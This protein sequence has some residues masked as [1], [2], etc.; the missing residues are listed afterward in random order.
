MKSVTSHITKNRH[1]ESNLAV[2]CAE[3]DTAFSGEN[4]GDSQMN[5]TP[6]ENLPEIVTSSEVPTMVQQ[7][8]CSQI[9]QDNFKQRLHGKRHRLTALDPVDTCFMNCMKQQLQT[10]L[11][12]FS[13]AY[14]QT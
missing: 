8:S 10:H 6:K 7:A 12:N 14:Y 4:E 5:E 13:T 3:E 1:Q 2:P 11:H 9:N